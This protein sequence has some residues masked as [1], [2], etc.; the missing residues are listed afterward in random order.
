M[1]RLCTPSPTTSRKI[2]Y[3]LD[4]GVGTEMSYRTASTPDR[5]IAAVV[6][7]S[8][9]EQGVGNGSF[10]RAYV[11]CAVFLPPSPSPPSLPS[12]PF[13]QPAVLSSFLSLLPWPI[14]AAAPVSPLVA[15][16]AATR[17]ASLFDFPVAAAEE[18]A[19]SNYV[20]ESDYCRWF[21]TLERSEITVG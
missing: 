2:D 18:S 6:G 13:G 20:L 21:A 15:A 3:W 8:I 5:L 14:P 1:P 16:G 4:G 17:P 10:A 12:P 11:I 9:A 7:Q 19:P